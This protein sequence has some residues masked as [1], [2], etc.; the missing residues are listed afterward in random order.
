MAR[1]YSGNPPA[2]A[3]LGHS[4]GPVKDE[5]RVARE[6]G[7]MRHCRDEHAVAWMKGGEIRR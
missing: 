2:P 4:C 3:S 5:G 1:T 6:G 7:G